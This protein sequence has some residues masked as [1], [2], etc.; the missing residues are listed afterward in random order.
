MFK[1]VFIL[2]LP[3]WILFDYLLLSE[4]LNGSSDYSSLIFGMIV[5]SMMIVINLD[6][7]LYTVRITDSEIQISRFIVFKKVVSLYSVKKKFKLISHRSSRLEAFHL[8]ITTKD[9]KT[10]KIRFVNRKLLDYFLKRGYSIPRHTDV[11]KK[12]IL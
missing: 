2:L 9:N 1:V 10:F 12:Y 6:M 7:L 4:L 11:K 8:E 3:M 5:I